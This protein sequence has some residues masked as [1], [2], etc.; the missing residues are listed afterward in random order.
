MGIWDY[1][2]A[3]AKEQRDRYLS[4]FQKWHRDDRSGDWLNRL[5]RVALLL[6]VLKAFLS[7]L[8]QLVR[9]EP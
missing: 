1:N 4:L 5:I 3:G 2:G 9:F 6:L 7:T 8:A